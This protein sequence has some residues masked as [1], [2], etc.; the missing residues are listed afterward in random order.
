MRGRKRKN[1]C[2]KTGWGL[3]QQIMPTKVVK[4]ALIEKERDGAAKKNKAPSN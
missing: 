4:E 2:T 3:G 1:D